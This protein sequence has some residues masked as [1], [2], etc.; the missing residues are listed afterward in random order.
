MSKVTLLEGSGSEIKIQVCLVP[1]PKQP[2][3]PGATELRSPVESIWCEDSQA[4]LYHRLLTLR[5]TSQ[6]ESY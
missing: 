5:I 6:Q 4:N 3:S 1:K 2:P